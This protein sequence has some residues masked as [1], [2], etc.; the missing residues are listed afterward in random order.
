MGKYVLYSTTNKEL[1]NILMMNGLHLEQELKKKEFT[2][3]K[4]WYIHMAI[5]AAGIY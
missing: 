1:E 3:T 2:K 5:E 4:V